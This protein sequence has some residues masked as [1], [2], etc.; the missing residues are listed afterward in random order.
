M[1]PN[2]V[3]GW[4]QASARRPA[5]RYSIE[6]AKHVNLK[7]ARTLGVTTAALA[8]VGF[9]LTA[10]GNPSRTEGSSMAG[11][12]ADNFM[13]ADQ[14]GLGYELFYY[15]HAPAIVIMAGVPGEKTT[16]KAKA[17]LKA[18]KAQDEG[19]GVKIFV[20]DSTSR[21]SSDIL[22][23]SGDFDGIPV[24]VD[25][26]QMVG[27][28]LGVK[29][30]GEAYVI[31]PKTWTIAYH[32]PVDASLS[33]KPKSGA[34]V[35]AA[36][37]ALVSGKPVQV[38]EAAL[39]GGAKIEIAS[40]GQ[41]AQF[42]KISYSADVAPILEAKCLS[43]HVKGGMAPFAM[44]RYETV[45]GF[46]PMI[47]EA[48]RTN[49]MPPF[50]S[51]FHGETWKDD[52][53]LSDAQSE[54]LVNWIEAGAPRGE[55]ADPLPAAQHT[56][57]EWPLGKPDLIINVPAFKVP[58]SGIVDY[59]DW[60]VASP[61]T[62]GKWLK[63]T[64]WRAGA[65][66]V[67]H[68]A[69][70]G[71]IPEVRADGRGFSW[72][73]SLGGYGPGGE[74][75]KTPADT[76]IY[77]PP[78]GSFAYQMHYTPVGKE[79]TD[80]TQV[81]YY[82]HKEKPKYILRQI[83]VTDFSI[84][85]PAGEERHHETAYLEFPR[86][87]LIF[88]TQPHCHSR[89]YSTK[90]R[91]RYP[92]GKEKLLLNQPRYD[93]GWQREYHFTN[94]FEVPAGSILIADYVFDNSVNNPSNPDPTHKVTFGEQTSEEMLFTFLR[95]RWKDETAENRHDEWMRELQQNVTFG[96]FDDNI[97]GK[98]TAA[99]FRNDPRFAPL[100]GYINVVDADKDGAL[101]KAEFSKAME[102]MSNMRRQ[103]PASA[104]AAPAPDKGTAAMTQQSN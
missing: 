71:W 36:V 17:A 82:F 16:D 65:V 33:A 27:R 48:V 40:R 7:L 70:A 52:M 74:E 18:L 80:A 58:A 62:E 86:D 84:E 51:D 83:S 94:L 63:T 10:A 29:R 96:A 78:G 4:S 45:K 20:L 104:P 95:F 102:I 68:H 72:N 35:A 34:S 77:V 5:D 38:R 41:T 91:I 32:G 9:A 101:S 42:A 11:M 67:V 8:L 39:K 25:R 97:D 13:L 26:M 66:P 47:R 54:T 87:A 76:G 59:Q 60:S 43:C 64:A 56:P 37:D 90:L 22:N 6:G 44:D 2:N 24:L 93:F 73:T 88:G 98:I 57:P 100:K 103:R 28:S 21:D 50:H 53:R 99:E 89:C 92:D 85:I 12:K 1:T 31:D 3:S 23:A 49:R 19:K 79:M 15:K 81:G 46:A 75:N 61:L 30:T 55:G 69:L 14:S